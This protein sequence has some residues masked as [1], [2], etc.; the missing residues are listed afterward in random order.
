MRRPIPRAALPTRRPKARPKAGQVGGVDD[1]EAFITDYL[2][3]LRANNAA[4]FIGAGLSRGAGY[5]DW[6]GLL[7][8]VAAGLGL[9][10]SKETDLVGVAQFH[11]NANAN[12]RHQLNQLLVNE[13]SDL[14]D[15]TENHA[16]LARLPIGIYWTTNYDRLIERALETS[17]KRADAK[18]TVKQLATTRRGRDAVIY[19]M[20][21]DIEH[22]ADAVL[23]KDDYERYHRTHGPFISALA[24]D[25]VEH[26][27]LFLGFSFTDPNLDY[28]LGRIRATFE[29]NQRRHFCLMK[30]RVRLPGESGK[31]YQYAINKQVLVTQDLM[32]FNIK[33]LFV[34]D[35]PEITTI[36]RT[37]VNRFR[38]RT[39]FIS[40]SA[41]DYGRWGRAT[42]E[43]FLVR[44]AAALIAGD[45]RIAS[46][47][48]LGI[49]G[50]IVTGATQQIYSSKVRSI[51]EQLIL[52][53]FPVG[54]T[55]PK[56]RESTFQRY[57][58]EL[59]A[60]AGIAIFV[61]G[62]K[63]A[64]GTVTDAGGMQEEFELAR[65]LGLHVIPVGASGFVSQKL[66][67][68]VMAGFGTF[69]PSAGSKIKGLFE[70]IGKPTARPEDLLDPIIEL[71]NLLS[72]E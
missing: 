48:G 26:T 29:G 51:D 38:R 6:V 34:D 3:E 65:R 18:Y 46:G 20:H 55:D 59:L 21:G 70:R 25:L 19:K 9:D 72:K 37:I 33:T 56:E 71:V 10:A 67:N 8:P 23:T 22:P 69:F 35:Y 43:D 7:A 52:R 32:R 58:E 14:H 30:K 15:P 41:A 13:F 60:Q 28:V 16:L 57:R 49:G 27:F 36:L 44:L 66:W 31:D 63:D 50:A 68:Q 2:K 42:T 54:I 17:G 64:S 1:T 11:V 47:F 53:P 12:N 62:N 45:Y 5:V 61:L 24:G 39:V 40:G 4:V